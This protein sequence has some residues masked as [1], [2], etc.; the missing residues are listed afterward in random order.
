MLQLEKAATGD[1]TEADY[2]R[3]IH[4]K[5]ASLFSVAART[6]A[7]SAD[8]TPEQEAA[9]EAF[10]AAFGTAFQIQDD[11]LDYAGTDA[12]GKPLG[13]DLR[14][15][16][17]TLPLLGALQ[18]SPLEEQVRAQVRDIPAHPEY[19]AHIRAFVLKRD[20][21]AYAARRLKEWVARAESALGAFP[22]SPAKAALLE[23]ARYTIRRQI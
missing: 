12:L 18:G 3:I 7:L 19:C 14:E 11:I 10:G 1:T 5:T 20:G 22:D 13:V 16:K 9:A 4:G 2:L 15:Q 23:I 21:I 17:I 6:G 8:A